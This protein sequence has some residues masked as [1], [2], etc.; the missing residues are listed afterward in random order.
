MDTEHIMVVN[1]QIAKWQ[2]KQILNL[3]GYRRT[4]KKGDLT[5]Y[6]RRKYDFKGPR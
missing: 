1:T 5:L 2:S 4:K 3:M 6:M